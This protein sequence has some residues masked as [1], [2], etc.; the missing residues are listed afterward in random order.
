MQYCMCAVPCT[1]PGGVFCTR[2]E[3]PGRFLYAM[4][5]RFCPWWIFEVEERFELRMFVG[6]ERLSILQS[7]PSSSHIFSQFLME[8]SHSYFRSFSSLSN[9]VC[10][11][12]WCFH[13]S[14]SVPSPTV[15]SN[16]LPHTLTR[17]SD[18]RTSH[19]HHLYPYSITSYQ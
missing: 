13:R 4:Y 6:R 19:Q 10:F 15:A 2:L 5:G 18:I 3:P 12:L 8:I 14:R 1:R 17:R 11:F 9:L 16:L 7:K